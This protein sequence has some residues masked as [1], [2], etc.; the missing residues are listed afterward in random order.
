MRRRPLQDI[1]IMN[2]L[3][4]AADAEAFRSGEP[5]A[6]A[7]HLILAA[8]ELPEGSAR[9]AFERIG[10]DPGG[11]RDA[12]AAQHDE[13]LRM[14]GAHRL[15][16]SIGDRLPEPPDKPRGPLR[17]SASAQELFKRVVKLIRKEKSQL[18][19]AYIVLAATDFED[20]TVARAFRQMGIRRADLRVAAREELD[21]INAS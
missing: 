13:A 18:Y 12:V 2:A 9:R 5:S 3:L 20:G 7:E 11:F 17:S 4:P 14:F 8:L 10:A 16:E 15:D 21:A 1:R 6:G 19:G